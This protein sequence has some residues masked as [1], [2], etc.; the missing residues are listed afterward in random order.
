MSQR[1]LIVPIG[2]GSF[3]LG[4]GRMLAVV[5]AELER[6]NYTV[7]VLSRRTIDSRAVAER[8]GVSLGPIETIAF[9]TRTW[10]RILRPIVDRWRHLRF[11]WMSRR[12]DLVWVQSPYIPMVSR[13]R[14][15]VLVT[16]FPFEPEPKAAFWRRRLDRYRV[17]A[18][19]EFGQRWIKRY[20]HVDAEC[21]YP[22]IGEI[23][24][25]AKKPMILAVGRFAG[26]S[27]TKGQLEMV[28]AFKRMLEQGLDGWTL[29][30][31]G[32]RQDDRYLA[33][34]E[35]EA[36][37]HPIEIRTDLEISDLESL[38][39]TASIF[40]H[41]AGL[42][43]DRERAPHSLEH[44]GIVVAEAM[45]AGCVPVVIDA[46]GPAEIVRDGEDGRV[47]STLEELCATTRELV[48]HPERL[49]TMSEAAARNARERFG[50][51][52]FVQ[53]LETFLPS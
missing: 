15:S 5:L 43:I 11:Q 3:G 6:R 44:F 47:F 34:V 16:D 23:E 19:S 10:P 36:R 8:F 40:W 35:A 39:G 45:T 22:S 32:L 25:R 46:G 27:R 41:A 29:C 18:I 12:Y 7:S 2:L 37:D 13:G 38:Y 53:R 48:D 20:W 17:I 9:G 4:I 50:H 28:R 33:A 14:H 21:F 31:A 51:H 24:P 52:A 26:G 49:K 30:L 1:A 42:G